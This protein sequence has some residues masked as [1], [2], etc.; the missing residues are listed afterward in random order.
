MDTLCAIGQLEE[1][2]QEDYV[3][4]PVGYTALASIAGMAAYAAYKAWGNLNFADVQYLY[5][6]FFVP[7]R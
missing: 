5:E 1:P 2:H 7:K 4:R 3:A 6:T